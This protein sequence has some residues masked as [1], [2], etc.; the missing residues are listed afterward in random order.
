V[1]NAIKAYREGQLTDAS[2]RLPSNKVEQEGLLAL[3]ALGVNPAAQQQQA[4]QAQSA[5]VNSRI[6]AD[7]A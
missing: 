2:P 4:Q 7:R 3:Q 5:A 1:G 6:A